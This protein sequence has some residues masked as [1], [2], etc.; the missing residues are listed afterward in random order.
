MSRENFNSNEFS[1]IDERNRE[2]EVEWFGT[3]NKVTNTIT[4]WGT[5]EKTEGS[6]M[7]YTDGSRCKD[8]VR[9]ANI[10]FIC[11]DSLK[12]IGLN[13]PTNCGYHFTAQIPCVCKQGSQITFYHKL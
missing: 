7:F 12:I 3:I 2:I 6:T 8:D 13:E 1:F 5:Y 11:G 10:S 9:S 4:K